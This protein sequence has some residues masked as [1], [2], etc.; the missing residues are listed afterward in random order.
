MFSIVSFLTE[1]WAWQLW[2]TILLH[3]Y[4]KGQQCCLID[5]L[6]V[7]TE[8]KH[9]AKKQVN[10]KWLIF[11][12]KCYYTVIGKDLYMNSAIHELWYQKYGVYM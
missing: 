10:L 12:Y 9:L 4:Q 6:N 2:L 5:V 11:A 3:F 8:A 1:I 7:Q